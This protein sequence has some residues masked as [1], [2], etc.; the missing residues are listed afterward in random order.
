M[1]RR[2]LGTFA[3][4][5]AAVGAHRAHPRE[6]R[7]ATDRFLADIDGDPVLALQ[8]NNRPRRQATAEAVARALGVEADLAL[9]APRDPA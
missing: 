5:S 9:A 7:E 6:V 1:R 8:Q 2:F 3:M 4:A